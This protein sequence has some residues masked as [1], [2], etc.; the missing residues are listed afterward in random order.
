MKKILGTDVVAQIRILVHDIQK[1]AR[2]YADFLGIDVPP[3]RMIDE[4]EKA[5]TRYKGKPSTARGS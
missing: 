2:V 3:V 5:Q 1:S 4:L